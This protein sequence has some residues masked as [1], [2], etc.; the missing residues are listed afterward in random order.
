MSNELS[1]EMIEK[2]LLKVMEIQEEYAH[3]KQN[4]KASRQAKMRD[5]LNKHAAEGAN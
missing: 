4:A 3:E 2:F 1:T 5:W